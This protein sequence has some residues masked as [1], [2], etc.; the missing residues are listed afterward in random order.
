MPAEE[1]STLGPPDAGGT[2]VDRQAIADT[3][4]RLLHAVDGRDWTAIAGVLAEQIRTDYT[5]LFGGSSEIETPD[6]L[7]GAWR[8][9]LPGFDATQHLTGPILADVSGG[10][11]RA[12]C[13][14]TAIHCI[15]RD[16]WTVSGYY[17]M[18]LVRADKSWRISAITYRNVLTA[19]DETLPQ[20][21]LERAQR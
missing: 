5:S 20:K 8:A 3:I 18:E 9:L 15:G 12:T 7:I 4:T 16:H 10:T 13:A 2:F 17:D 1:I 11:A 6:E 21:A 14:V 19:G